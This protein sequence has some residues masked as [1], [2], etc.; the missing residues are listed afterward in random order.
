MGLRMEDGVDVRNNGGG[1]LA[2]TV[3]MKQSSLLIDRDDD[4]DANSQSESTKLVEQM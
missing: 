4:G 1:W 2:L 3:V